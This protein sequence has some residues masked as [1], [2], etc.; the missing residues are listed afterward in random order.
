M[1]TPCTGCDTDKETR[2]GQWWFLRGYFGITGQFCP[3]CYDKISHDSYQQ[4]R[5]PAEYT[6]MLLKLSNS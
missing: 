6:L 1:R 2:K 3:D 4:P 5:H